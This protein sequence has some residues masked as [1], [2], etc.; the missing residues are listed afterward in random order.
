MESPFTS[1]SLIY[2]I[3]RWRKN[4]PLHIQFSCS[5]VSDCLRPHGLQH[6]RPP[7]LSPTPG[8]CSDSCPSSWWC[9]LTITSPSPPALCLSRQQGLFQWVSSHIR[10]PKYWSF[11][12]ITVLPMS[13]QGWFPF[14]WTGLISLQ[15][16]DSQE[17]FP[18]SPFTGIDSLIL[19]FLHDPTLITTHDYWKNH[20]FDCM[21]LCH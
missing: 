3:S 7:C 5:V 8:A 18:T 21:D 9:H 6:S 1:L 20:I 12:F 13:I 14:G 10:W 4:M 11:S 15:S 2:F 16:K 19:S 17:S